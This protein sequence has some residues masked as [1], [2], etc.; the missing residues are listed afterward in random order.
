MNIIRNKIRKG[1]SGKYRGN[2]VFSGV[3]PDPTNGAP[4]TQI[5][6]LY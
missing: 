6:F 1:I 5:Q 4:A 2:A 3:S